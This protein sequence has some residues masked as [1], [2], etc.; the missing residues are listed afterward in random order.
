[1]GIYSAAERFVYEMIGLSKETAG[2]KL[3]QL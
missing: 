2:L 1:M 3:I